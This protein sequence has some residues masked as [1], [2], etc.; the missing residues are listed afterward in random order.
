[1][2]IQI[3]EVYEGRAVGIVEILEQNKI[4]YDLIK[5]FQGDPLQN[6]GKNGIIISGGNPSLREIEKHPYLNDVI[7]Y[8][9]KQVEEDAPILGICLGHQ[10]LATAIGGKIRKSKKPEV[11]FSPVYHDVN[12]LTVGVPSPF[13]VFQYHFDEVFSLPP[14]VE[15]FSYNDSCSIQGFRLRGKNIYGVQYHPEISATFG[16]GILR[17]SVDLL[18]AKNVNPIYSRDQSN[19]SGNRIVENFVKGCL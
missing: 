11:G 12:E 17:G 14:N 5:P 18:K 13:L 4:P 16:D 3:I 9:E 15:V 1:M 7:A 10:I 19:L 8:V 2:T 6:E